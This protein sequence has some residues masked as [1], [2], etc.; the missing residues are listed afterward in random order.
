V[1]AAAIEPDRG[2]SLEADDAAGAVAACHRATTLL[3]TTRA[4]PP[5][6]A[7]LPHSGEAAKLSALHVHV[8]GV[9]RAFATIA[10]DLHHVDPP[11]GRLH[12]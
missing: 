6:L 12:D 8:V 11:V 5:V 2:L 4:A 1:A 3:K 9:E 7:F 10:V